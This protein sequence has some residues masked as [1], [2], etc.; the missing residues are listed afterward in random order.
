MAHS[1]WSLAF[2]AL[3]LAAC[4]SNDNNDTGPA[5][6]LTASVGAV[7]GDEADAALNAMSLPTQ[8][9]PVGTSAGAPCATPSST[10]DSDG[11]GIPDDATWIFTA[12]P[13]RFT[14][15]RGGTL[16][17]VGQLRI[18]DPSLGAAGFGYAATLT[19]LRATVTTGGNNPETYS[20][21]RNGTRSLDG[22]VAEL[23]LTADLQVIRTFTGLPDA[24][25]D[26]AW[27]ARFTA[28]TPLQINQPLPSGTL[29]INGTFGW[30]RGSETLDLTITTPTPI[31]YNAGCNN[32][33]RFDAGELHAAGSFD[34][35]SGYVR[36]RWTACGAEPEIKFVA[37]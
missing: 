8:L 3:C 28:D 15:Y 25:V 7:S 35:T 29:D 33:R 34:G 23:L 20:V 27:T 36:V 14:G 9:A 19:A 18:Q 11:D 6:E 21:T 22:T 16:D 32:T 26:E 5:A 2:V 10:T 4:G 24:A 17:V 1:A 37:G 30:I 31:H 13:C 12:P